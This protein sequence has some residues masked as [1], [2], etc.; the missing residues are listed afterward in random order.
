MGGGLFDAVGKSLSIIVLLYR[1][2]PV[3]VAP[4]AILLLNMQFYDF[5]FLVLTKSI[6]CAII[7]KLYGYS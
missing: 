5:L 2:I 4:L 3:A 1:H 7:C 6:K